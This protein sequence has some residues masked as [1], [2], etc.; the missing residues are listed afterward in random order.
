LIK[1]WGS[2]EQRTTNPRVGGS[3]STFVYTLLVRRDEECSNKGQ[4]MFNT[5]FAKNFLK[6]VFLGKKLMF[7]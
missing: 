6:N 1:N 4:R 3:G 5:I 7:S 2:T